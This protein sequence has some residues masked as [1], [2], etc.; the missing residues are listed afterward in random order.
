MSLMKL[1]RTVSYALHAT[2]QLARSESGEA[3]VPCSR[4]ASAGGMPERF[5]LQILRS[6]VSHGILESTRGVEGGYTLGR[7]PEKI[8]LLDVIEA[9]RGP[10]ASNFPIHDGLPDELKLKLERTFSGVA[11]YTR[12]ELGAVTL[13]HL[14][15]ETDGRGDGDGDG[16]LSP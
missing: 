9:V 7:S 10:V 5:L 4:L 2:L 13:A 3:P 11:D 16:Q 6:L 14:M 8:S 1:S 12:Q 15:A